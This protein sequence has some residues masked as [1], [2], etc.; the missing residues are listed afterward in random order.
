MKK[1][2][3]IINSYLK[4]NNKLKFSISNKALEKT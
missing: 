2:N 3:K 1:I 4:I